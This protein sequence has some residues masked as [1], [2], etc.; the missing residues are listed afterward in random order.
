M[1]VV[2]TKMINNTVYKYTYSN[3][4]FYIEREGVLYTDAIDPVDSDR[5]Y[6][7]TDKRIEE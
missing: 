5:V 1:I 4:G 6:T 3:E 2:E 7:E